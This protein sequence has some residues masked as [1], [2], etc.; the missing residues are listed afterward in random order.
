LHSRFLEFFRPD[1][2]HKQVDEEQQGDDPDDDG[3]H[4]V[5]LKPVAKAHV[6][7][8]HDE[9]QEHDADVD[10]VAHKLTPPSA[11]AAGSVS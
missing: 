9:K 11:S 1:H 10:E 6:K 7:S 4:K 3:F 8:A 5:L 2:R